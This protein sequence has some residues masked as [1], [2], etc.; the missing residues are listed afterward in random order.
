MNLK[1]CIK[2]LMPNTRLHLNFTN[3]VCNA[4]FYYENYKVSK[5]KIDWKYRQK[6]FEKLIQKIKRVNAPNFDALVPVS[7]G[8]DSIFQV[9]K[10]LKKDLRILAVNID[11][12]IKTKIGIC[13]L[14]NISKMGATLITVKPNLKIHKKILKISFFEYGDPDLMS[15][16]MLH[17]FP[18]RIAL[19]FKIPLVLLGENSAIEYSGEIEKY[20]AKKI[21]YKWFKKFAANSNLTPKKFSKKHKI[22]YRLLKNY[23]LPSNSELKKT[24]AVFLSYYF[25]WNSE[26]NL[27]I[28]KKYGFKSLKNAS[29][30]TYRNFVGIDEKINRIH[31][32]LKFLK[33]GYGRATDHAC[34]DIR[35]GKISRRKGQNLVM[36][37]D[38]VPISKYYYKEFINLIGINEKKFF[39][40]LKKYTNKKLF[41][42]KGK[43]FL[44]KLFKFD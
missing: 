25:K 43:L 7:G 24:N 6:E 8:K 41:K 39:L 4:C 37:F 5:N 30:G 34:E 11:Y 31:Q 35:N 23:D 9:H 40:I 38:R 20:N 26:E 3:G 27:K 33:F 14:Q 18:I 15:H 32:Y 12:G 28:A 44:L 42:I 2:C 10:L 13:N 29:E 36:K 19:N 1:Y 21:D 16:C 22:D 17:A